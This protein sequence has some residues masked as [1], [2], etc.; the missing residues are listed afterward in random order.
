MIN[1]ANKSNEEL[2][3]M[4]KDFDTALKTM[5]KSRS[6][7]SAAKLKTTAS[8]ALEYI[9]KHR[10]ECAEMCIE[11]EKIVNSKSDR[12]EYLLPIFEASREALWYMINNKRT[13]YDITYMPKE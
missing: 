9:S 10:M 13:D 3:Q 6:D 7:N 2:N 4:F 5:I 11:L 12:H 1:E 8:T